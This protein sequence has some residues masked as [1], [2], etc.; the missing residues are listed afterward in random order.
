MTAIHGAELTLPTHS[1]RSR[2]RN[3]GGKA[4]NQADGVLG[5][6]GRLL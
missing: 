5:F 1:G 2:H 3:A 4:D 6:D